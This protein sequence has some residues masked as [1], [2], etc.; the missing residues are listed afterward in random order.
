M[1]DLGGIAGQ[2]NIKDT[3]TLAPK[4]VFTLAIKTGNREGLTIRSEVIV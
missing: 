4:S 1:V 3:R 2:A